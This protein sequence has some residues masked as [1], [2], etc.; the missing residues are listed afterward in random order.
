MTEKKEKL[1]VGVF[2]NVDAGKSTLIGHLLYKCGLVD[3]RVF[4]QLEQSALEV[5]HTFCSFR[6]GS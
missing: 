2:G 6:L 3:R 1:S 5:S 4:G